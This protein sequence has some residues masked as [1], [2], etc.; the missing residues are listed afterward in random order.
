MEFLRETG[1]FRTERR[2]LVTG[3]VV[4][5]RRRIIAG[6]A[7]RQ[8]RGD[9]TGGRRGEAAPSL[10]RKANT[11]R[12]PLRNAPCKRRSDVPPVR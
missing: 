10:V 2:P 5:K 11:T 4:A 12:S 6:S 1:I 3:V 7:G 9:S 8:D